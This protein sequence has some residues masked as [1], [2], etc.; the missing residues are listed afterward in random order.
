M[1]ERISLIIFLSC[2]NAVA[3]RRALEVTKS[4]AFTAEQLDTLLKHE[5]LD[6]RYQ[7]S[8]IDNHSIST[9]V[10][11]LA[12][13]L[14]HKSSDPLTPSGFVEMHSLEYNYTKWPELEELLENWRAEVPVLGNL[15]AHADRAR[16]MV[17]DNY[18]DAVRNL[19]DYS[20]YI[21]PFGNPLGLECGCSS[22]QIRGA[23]RQF[24]QTS[25]DEMESLARR[26]H[27]IRDRIASGGFFHQ[28]VIHGASIFRMLGEACEKIIEYLS[29]F[30]N[31]C[32]TNAEA[33]VELKDLYDLIAPPDTVGTFAYFEETAKPVT[34]GISAARSEKILHLVRSVARAIKKITPPLVTVLDKQAIM[35]AN[36]VDIA[37]RSLTAVQQ[38][39]NLPDDLED[40]QGIALFLEQTHQ[41]IARMAGSGA[42]HLERFSRSQNALSRSLTR[43]NQAVPALEEIESWHSFPRLLAGVVK[44]LVTGMPMYQALNQFAETAFMMKKQWQPALDLITWLKY[45]VA[46]PLGKVKDKSSEYLVGLVR[47]LWPQFDELRRIKRQVQ[48]T[49][50]RMLREGEVMLQASHDALEV[51]SE[52]LRT[53]IRD[54]VLHRIEAFMTQATDIEHQVKPDRLQ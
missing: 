43:T 44:E 50:L 12:D 40:H 16:Q 33:V 22:E 26:A 6:S 41:W 21:S 42:S 54:P 3:T 19:G 51:F 49:A 2:I 17:V 5:L 7:S 20:N 52:R 1:P 35:N 53:D 14:R 37:T 24:M 45:H 38:T 23:F 32:Q 13:A 46:L 10:T 48:E 11:I 31:W 9:N 8:L 27:H 28:A 47:W 18:E 25:R 34:L 29:S 39:A 4:A 30:V 36:L 15:L